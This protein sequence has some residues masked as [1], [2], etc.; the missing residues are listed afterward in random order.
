M[1]IFRKHM[2]SQIVCINYKFECW[3]EII[4]WI[5][6]ILTLLIMSNLT[7]IQLDIAMP[8]MH[9]YFMAFLK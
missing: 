5:V 1:L 3:N 7:V 4:K 8:Y 6:H 9:K 2:F